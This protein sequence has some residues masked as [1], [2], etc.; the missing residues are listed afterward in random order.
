M[1]FVIARSSKGRPTLQHLLQADDVTS[2]GLLMTGWSRAY[3]P[4][5][6]RAVLCKKCA[7]D[8]SQA[9]TRRR[10]S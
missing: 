9:E 3:Q 6:I 2:C 7:K 1:I 4:L 5:P 8:M 10:M